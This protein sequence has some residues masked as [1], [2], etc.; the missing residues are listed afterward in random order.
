VPEEKLSRTSCAFDACASIVDCG[1][2]AQ[3][4]YD[5]L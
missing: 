4:L 2:V 5:N 1:S 3:P